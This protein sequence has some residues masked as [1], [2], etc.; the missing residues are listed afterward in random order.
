MQQSKFNQHSV[1]STPSQSATASSIIKKGKTKK[2]VKK[3]NLSNAE[4]E[5][6]TAADNNRENNMKSNSNSIPISTLTP[7]PSKKEVRI[8]DLCQEDKSKIAK[9]LLSVSSLKQE[10]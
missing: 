3:S 4:S 8:P 1:P 10:E 7:S 5:S 6:K 9:L 2:K